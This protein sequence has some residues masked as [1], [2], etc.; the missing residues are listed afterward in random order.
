MLS[1]T[2]ANRGSPGVLWLIANTSSGS[3]PSRKRNVFRQY[4][5]TSGN[6]PPPASAFFSRHWFGSPWSCPLEP[7]MSL[8][9]PY[10]FSRTH[11]CISRL[12]GSYWMR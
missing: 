6:A 1:S 3:S 4:K 10:F 11:F 2:S 5:P 12:F 8:T 7:S 9:G